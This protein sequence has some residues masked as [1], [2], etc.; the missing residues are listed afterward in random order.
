MTFSIEAG[1]WMLPAVIT[2]IIWAVAYTKTK[3]IGPST[4][5]DY[6][7]TGVAPSFCLAYS[8][9]ADFDYV[10]NLC[11]ADMTDTPVTQADCREWFY[12]PIEMP[13]DADGNGPASHKEA[14]KIVYEVWDRCCDTFG[15]Y[16]HLSDAINEAMRL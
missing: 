7:M 2:I 8:G 12:Y 16:E 5:R 13:L 14:V 1:W 4:G 15:S 10:A 3:E 6:G 9:G 11:G